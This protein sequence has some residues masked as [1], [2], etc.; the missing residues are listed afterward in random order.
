M[1]YLMCLNCGEKFYAKP[2]FIKKGRAKYCSVKCYSEFKGRAYPQK[3]PHFKKCGECQ[4][5][6]EILSFKYRERKYC[7]QSCAA[8]H[9][10]KKRAGIRYK[11]I[12]KINLE[13]SFRANLISKYGKICMVPGCDYKKFVDAHHIV[14][15]SNGGQHFVKNGILLC[16]NHH[17]EADNG[18]IDDDILFQYKKEWKCNQIGD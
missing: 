8:I 18:L 11:N 16:P 5:E 7:S 1:P 9:S 4:K 2:N 12:D 6:F 17:R 10:N 14:S 13:T 15:R 3:Y